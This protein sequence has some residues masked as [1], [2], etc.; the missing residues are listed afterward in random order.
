VSARENILGRVAAAA[1]RV[2]AAPEPFVPAHRR[3]DFT[4]FASQLGAAGGRL[5][6]PAGL[7][8]RVA[9]LRGVGAGRPLM[10]TLSDAA[11][12]RLGAGPWSPVPSAGDGDAVL[13]GA[14][15]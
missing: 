7:S 11:L 15:A 4:Q 5:G 6:P 10:L 13:R 2:V 9:Q 1:S 14:L 12:L 8:A 3:A